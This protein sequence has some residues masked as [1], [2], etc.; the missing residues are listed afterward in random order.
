MNIQKTIYDNEIV[1]FVNEEMI[2]DSIAEQIISIQD[3]NKKIALDLK[4]VKSIKS[5]YFLNCL[6][7]DKF[8]LF[9][10]QSEV[11]LYLGLT[12]K[13]GFLNSYLNYDDFHNNKR[14]FIKRRFKLV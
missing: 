14:E 13:S 9:N 8:K 1:F 6:I 2:D 5:D 11:L 12:L 4:K 10:I 7:E 3:T